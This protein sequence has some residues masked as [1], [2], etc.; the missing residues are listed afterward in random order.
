MVRYYYRL[1]RVPT[2]LLSAPWSILCLRSCNPP[3]LQ[4]ATGAS[5]HAISERT[6]RHL[7]STSANWSVRCRIGVRICHELKSSIGSVM[8]Q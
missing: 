7:L 6:G 4:R 1:H 5:C 8:E 2:E 3:L